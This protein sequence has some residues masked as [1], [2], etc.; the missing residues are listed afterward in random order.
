MLTLLLS[1]I[2]ASETPNCLLF[3]NNDNY[4][5]IDNDPLKFTT[6][7]TLECWFN[8]HEFADSAALIDFS[9]VLLLDDHYFGY[10]IYTMDS[11]RIAIRMGNFTRHFELI[12]DSVKTNIWQHL[13]ITYDKYKNDENVV[14]F[15]NG[16]VIQKADCNIYLE[17]P[18]TFRPYGVFL[19]AYYDYPYIKSFKGELDDVRFWSVLRTNDEIRNSMDIEIDPNATGLAGY[20]TFDQESD[21]L[22]LDLSKNENHGKLENMS[23]SSWQLS[24]AQ[25][26][27]VQ[28]SDVSFDRLV[29]SWITSPSFNSYCVDL[30]PTAD[31]SESFSGFPVSDV[32]TDYYIIDKI[33]PG[34]YYYRVKGHFEGENPDDEPWT[35]IQIVSTMTDAA[36]A[37]ELIEF[38]VLPVKDHILVTWQTATQ[39]ENAQFILERKTQN[40]DWEI[41]HEISGAG[42]NSK[43]MSYEFKDKQLVPGVNY[44]Y[45]LSDIS[46]SGT[47]TYSNILSASLTENIMDNSQTFTLDT[48]YPNPFNPQISILFTVQQETDILISIYSTQGELL[49]VICNTHFQAGKY[50]FIW[51]PEDIASGVYLLK[52]N[53]KDNFTTHKLLYLK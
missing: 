46:Y 38:K 25:L 27:V 7:Y 2:F 13:A 36:T 37:I 14:V 52:I 29:L 45:R 5:H 39:T 43:N 22:L 31:F 19:G 16:Q 20:Y 6:R 28:P 15:L 44:S 4:V 35:D 47:V 30:S 23:D 33:I 24:Y 42:T 49:D 11:N 50:S 18:E 21:S 1:A 26:A 41:I 12:I 40:S 34:T 32:T 8:V 10:G 9:T 51:A 53:S 3:E 48:V 17:Y